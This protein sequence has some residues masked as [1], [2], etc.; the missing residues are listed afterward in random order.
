MEMNNTTGSHTGAGAS[1]PSVLET[2]EN[3]Y[4]S[5]L[6]CFTIILLG[7]CTARLG[8]ISPTASKG[9]SVFVSLM[10][11]PALLFKSM[12]QLDFSRVNWPFLNSI[13]IGKA[14]VFFTV[15]LFTL[16]LVRP[17]NLGKAGIYAIFSVQSNDL[18]LGYPLR[19]C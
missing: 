3:L 17:T 7:Y 15:M 5:L 14:V 9:I 10:A 19:K 1:G 11:L 16:V 4:P 2:F 12:V 18:A 13:L 6:Q 8:Y